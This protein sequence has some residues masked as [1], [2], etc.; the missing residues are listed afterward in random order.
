MR[1]IYINGRFLTQKTTGVQRVAEEIVK[2]IDNLLEDKELSKEFNF[3]ILT[4]KNVIKN[5]KLKRIQVQQ[6][7][8]LKGHLW[9]QL[10]LPIYSR[11]DILINFCNTGPLFKREQ[12]VF[13]HDAAIYSKPDG[14]SKKFVAWYKMVYKLVSKFS[15][16]IITVSNFSKE[17]LISNL[18]DVAS[19]IRVIKIGVD[20]IEKVEKDEG[21]LKKFNLEKDNFM[22]AVGSLHPN[23]NF[24]AILSALD[25]MQNFAGQVVIA[26]GIDKKV[27][28]EETSGFGGN[29]TYVGY[30]TDEE[31]CGLY[32]NAKVFIFPSIYEGFGL[33]PIEAMR[34]GCPVIASKVASIPEVCK[35]GAVYFNPIEP[36]EL[37]EKI[38]LFYNNQI[39]KNELTTKALEIAKDYTWKKTAVELIDTLRE[40]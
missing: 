37:V 32:S 19:K 34:L 4:P 9:E 11:G 18:P 17:E 24:K 21:I 8:L 20:H 1:K 31:L 13:I 29:I 30:V 3:I 25:H 22:L 33:P 27:V 28:S 10:E 38:K 23:K 35:D 15:R 40:K 6:V 36:S 14:F 2:E 5:I 26:G 7:G 39:D 12:V 16:G